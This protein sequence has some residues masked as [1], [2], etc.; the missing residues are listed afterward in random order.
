MEATAQSLSRAPSRPRQRDFDGLGWI[1]VSVPIRTGMVHYPGNPSVRLEFVQQLECGDPATVSKLTLGVHTGTHVDAPVHFIRN[2]SGVDRLPLETLIGVARVI[3]VPDVEAVT[4][5]HLAP[6]GIG[7]S[8]RVLLRTRNSKRCWNTEEFVADYSYLSADAAA[9][10]AKRGVR[11][12]GIDYLSIGG[13]ES[14]IEV[15]HILLGAGIVILEGLDLSEASA[16][17]YDLI[18]LPL[19]LLGC[20]GSP[21]RALLR[22]RA[23]A[24]AP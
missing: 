4:A 8:E 5:E 6:H 22:P 14:I 10:L 12:I 13:G 20:D 7:A 17:W 24:C 18:C 9:L 2:A 16:G 19:R 3:D 15:H 11:M 23:E 1:D 21:A